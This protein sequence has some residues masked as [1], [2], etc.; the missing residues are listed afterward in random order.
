M[1]YFSSFFLGTLHDAETVVKYKSGFS[2]CATEITRY[3]SKIEK[4]D[5][6]IKSNIMTHLSQCMNN[7]SATMI[8]SAEHTATSR[9]QNADGN[10]IFKTCEPMA[11]TSS[12][13]EKERK[14]DSESESEAQSTDGSPSSTSSGESIPRKRMLYGDFQW[15]INGQIHSVKGQALQAVTNT[16]MSAAM[17]RQEEQQHANNKNSTQSLTPDSNASKLNSPNIA[18]ASPEIVKTC[19]VILPHHH[20]VSP[21]LHP[22]NEIPGQQELAAV[23]SDMWR[24]W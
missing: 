16:L 17:D 20:P 9:G 19:P 10:P 11:S 14:T 18:C 3:L 24:P 15:V 6:A 22:A 12:Q 7:I 1:L 13:S 21:S 5:C 4:L 8:Q 23:E 2:E